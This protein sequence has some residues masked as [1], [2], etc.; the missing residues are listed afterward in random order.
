M[1]AAVFIAVDWGTTSFRAY[2]VDT[3]GEVLAEVSAAEGILAVINGDFDAALEKHISAWPKALPILAAGMI[4]SRQGWIERPYV[5]CPADASA[6]SKSLFQHQMKSGRVVYFSTGL[7]FNSPTLGHDVMRSE[8]TQVFGS[9]ASGAELFIT[10][11]THS[12]WIDVRGETITG[13][14]T[15]ITGE[16]FALLKNHSILGRLMVGDESDPLAFER[17]V[18]AALRDPAGLSH[19]LFSARSLVLFD[20]LKSEAAHSYLSGLVIGAEVAYALMSRDGVKDCV[21]L[22]SPKIGGAYV[23]ALDVAGVKARYGDPQAIVK[24]L[25]MIGRAA[26]VIR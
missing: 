13:F 24:G 14:A 16:L 20:D 3:Q 17:G 10:P 23:A 15:Y 2:Q 6:M 1:T 26:G 18:N 5:E 11:G 9:L 21:V 25:H 22:A 7:H 12:K 4:T 19:I 8:E